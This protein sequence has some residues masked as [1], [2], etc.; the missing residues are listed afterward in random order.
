MSSFELQSA[1]RL[2]QL[3][4]RADR[5]EE[6]LAKTRKAIDAEF[7]TFAAGK[8]TNRDRLRSQLEAVGMLP[9]TT[10]AHRMSAGRSTRP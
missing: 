9:Y 7:R 4:Q 2:A 5:M 6:A 8:S 10:P 1:R 3:F